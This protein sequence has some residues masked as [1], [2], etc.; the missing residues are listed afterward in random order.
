MFLTCNQTDNT[1]FVTGKQKLLIQQVDII[2]SFIETATEMYVTF[3]VVF[4][5]HQCTMYC[6]L[7]AVACT[8]YIIANVKK[9]ASMSESSPTVLSEYSET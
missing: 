5:V 4:I 1:L 2:D 7:D 9:F 6:S 3:G 8:A